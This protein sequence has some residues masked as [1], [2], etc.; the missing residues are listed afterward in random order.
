MAESSVR[1]RETE[2][3]L[4]KAPAETGS[5]RKSRPMRFL[6]SGTDG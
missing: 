1:D 2:R 5:D 4:V 3:N 6:R